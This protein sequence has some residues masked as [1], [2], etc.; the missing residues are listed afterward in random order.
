MAH[1]GTWRSLRISFDV[2]ADLLPKAL[3]TEGFG[4]VLFERYDGGVE[5][6]VINPVQQL[7]AQSGP[8]AELAHEVGARLARVAQSLS[9]MGETR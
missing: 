2:A 3:R 6:G 7:D 8:L 4:V 1:R 5:L 9:N